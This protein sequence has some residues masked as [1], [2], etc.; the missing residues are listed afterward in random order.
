MGIVVLKEVPH[1]PKIAGVIVM[2]VG[3]IL[4]AIG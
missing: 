3:L 2:F 4:V 1:E